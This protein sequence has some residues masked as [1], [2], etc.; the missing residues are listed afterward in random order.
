[1]FCNKCGAQNDDSATSCQKCGQPLP[2]TPAQPKPSA[3]QPPPAQAPQPSPVY[4]VQAP[5]PPKKKRGCLIA[6]LVGVAVLVVII[7]VIV[8]TCTAAVDSVLSATATPPSLVGRA[9]GEPAP[10]TSG[11]PSA[12]TFSTGDVIQASDFKLTIESFKK[13][14]GTEYNKPDDGKEWVQIVLLVENTSDAEVTVSS[15]MMFDA[16]VD[17]MAMSENYSAQMVD[18]SIK[19]MDGTLAAGKKLRGQLAYEVPK[20][21]KEIQI[22]LDAAIFSFFDSQK[23]TMVFKNN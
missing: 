5:P 15:M 23:I 4:V 13:V 20:G 18:E 22:D 8:S 3:P 12:Q 1:M 21:W 2:A 10:D 11:A 19:S 17:D 16:Y 9:S 7:I 6:S 14:K